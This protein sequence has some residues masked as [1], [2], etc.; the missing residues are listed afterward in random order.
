ML[1]Q[2]SG[3][4]LVAGDIMTDI[5]VRPEGPL[6]KG[7]DRRAEIRALPGGSGANQSAWLAHFEVPVALFARVGAADLESLAMDLRGEGISPLLAPDPSAQ[8]G[9]LVTIVDPDG[10]RSFFTDRGANLA[11]S[12]DDLPKDWLNMTGLLV[13]SGYSFFAPGP[14]AAVRAMMV[15]ARA[16]GIPVVIDPASAGFLA[17]CG[18][19]TF[20]EWTQGADVLIANADEA[21]ILSGMVDVPDQIAALGEI[22]E[23][24]VLKSGPDGAQAGG[25]AGIAA[26]AES[27]PVEAVDTTG[28]GDAFLAGVIAAWRRGS[29]L[30]ECLAAGNAAGAIAVQYLGGRPPKKQ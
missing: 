26:K 10:E 5:I 21:A 25:R 24:V 12:I 7:S 14:R 15:A 2:I 18:A 6:V 13:L 16:A 28:A 8:S 30:S 23:L 20:I 17:E 27:V 9:R 29:G 22:Y 11:L 19:A 1:P 4:V 3:R